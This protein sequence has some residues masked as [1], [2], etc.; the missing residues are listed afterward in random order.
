MA[1]ETTIYVQETRQFY[2]MRYNAAEMVEIFTPAEL[3][4]LER[5]QEIT[6][7]GVRMVSGDALARMAF[8]G[9]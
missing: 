6:K 9:R 5:G 2:A 4:A 3:E 1:N 7:N 8:A